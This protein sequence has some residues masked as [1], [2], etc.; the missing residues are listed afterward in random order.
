MAYG[1]R[2]AKAKSKALY[3]YLLIGISII[4]ILAI[5]FARLSLSNKEID[6]STLCP[7]D[8]V[9]IYS[10]II[11]DKSDSYSEVQKLF[12][13]RYFDTF[14]N[15]LDV[16]EKVSIFFLD[17][18]RQ[19]NMDPLLVLCNPDDGTNANPIYEN[20]KK[21]KKQ[22]TEKFS[23][24]LDFVLD[25]GLTQSTLDSSPILK[26]IQGVSIN[27][28]PTNDAKPSKKRLII[29]SD[30]LEHTSE[31]SHYKQKVDFSKFRNS[32]Y[33]NQLTSYLDGVEVY[34]LY[35]PRKGAEHIQTM[36][37]AQF[38]DEYISSMGGVII[39]ITRMPG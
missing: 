16:G 33:F 4:V 17:D 18:D 23:E 31:Y 21:L 26:L 11:F 14:K 8:P 29:V 7:S 5:T 38:W 28:F 30:M 19:L 22:W 10:T 27:G 3:G 1:K 36:Q 15:S 39:M 32:S 2:K 25:K 20:P 12:L 34:I 37:H 24:R 13:K 9:N 6:K 35:L